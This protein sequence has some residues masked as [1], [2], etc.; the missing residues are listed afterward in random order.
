MCSF[1]DSYK[2][3]LCCDSCPAVCSLTVD[4]VRCIVADCYSAFV[5]FSSDHGTSQF[6]P[7]NMLFGFAQYHYFCITLLSAVMLIVRHLFIQF[8]H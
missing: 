8:A 1:K 4:V 3:T 7:V 6:I 5:R 2:V